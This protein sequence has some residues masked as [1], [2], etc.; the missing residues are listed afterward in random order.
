MS[1][2]DE[3]DQTPDVRED[4]LTR[5]FEEFLDSETD[6][7]NYQDDIATMLR[8]NRRRLVVNIDHLRAYKPELAEDLLN[9]PVDYFP[10]FESA[11]VE[12]IA[13]AQNKDKQ[14]LEQEGY[15]VGLSGSFGDHHVSPR[16]LRAA[17]LGRMISL[18]GIVTRCSLV[19]PKLVKSVHYCPKN[20]FFFA[21]DY[22]DALN[23]TPNKPQTSSVTPVKDDEGNLLVTEFGHCVF[24]D[25]QRISIQE[26]PERSPAGQLPRSTDVI[27]DDDLVDKC[28]PGDRIQLVGSYRSVGGGANGAFKYGTFLLS[29][30]PFDSCF[31][32]VTYCC[33]QYQF[34]LHQDRRRYCRGPIDT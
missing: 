7:Y 31:C 15:H 23:A 9:Q 14:H 10:A 32:K 25:H 21:H 6:F 28:K 3:P 8:E 26:M 17:Q 19:R 13:R 20:R 34:T 18:E 29:S 2:L 12:V 1:F 5:L 33:K 30:Y 22:R 16:T 24:R 11:L 27:L 4:Q